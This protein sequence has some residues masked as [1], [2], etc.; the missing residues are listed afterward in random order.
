MH[1]HLIVFF[2]R[3]PHGPPPCILGYR[4]FVLVGRTITQGLTGYGTCPYDSP[5]GILQVLTTE[6]TATIS[7][8]M[9]PV[10]NVRKGGKET[11]RAR[12]DNYNP[13]CFRI[14]S[15]SSRRS[16]WS[17]VFENLPLKSSRNNSRSI[18]LRTSPSPSSPLAPFRRMNVWWKL[19]ALAMLALTSIDLDAS[20]AAVNGC[21]DVDKDSCS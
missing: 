18:C 3:S 15:S 17:F 1:Y 9:I 13:P 19:D 16:F 14:S 11:T 2:I 8:T 7:Q 4:C 10:I 6:D 21:W 5:V 20:F 12:K